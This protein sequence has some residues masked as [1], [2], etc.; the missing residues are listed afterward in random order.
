MSAFTDIKNVRKAFR[1]L[2]PT[3]R[4]LALEMLKDDVNSDRTA[5]ARAAKGK[6]GR[7]KGSKNKPKP[8][9]VLGETG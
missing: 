3:A 9:P 6:G 2:D 7:R 8:V 4:S 1:K 5:K